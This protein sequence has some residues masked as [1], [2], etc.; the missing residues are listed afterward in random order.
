MIRYRDLTEKEKLIICN[1]WG[2]KAGWVPVPE[3]LF[4]ASCNHHD[5]NYW[6]GC[7]EQDRARADHQFLEAMLKDAGKSKKYQTLA[8][9]Y[10][11]AVRL[12]G[13]PF[14]HYSSRERNEDDL[15][16]AILEAESWKATASEKKSPL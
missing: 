11:M 14:F 8:F 3:F 15:H 12:F 1:G 4:H 7:T 16:Q 5:F 6:L 9:T 2:P 10:W 13:A